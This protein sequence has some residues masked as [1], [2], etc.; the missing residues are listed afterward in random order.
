MD[1]DTLEIVQIALVWLYKLVVSK[2]TAFLASKTH[3]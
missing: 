2:L 1:S 3:T